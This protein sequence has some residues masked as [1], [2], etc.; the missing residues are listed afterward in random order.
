[1]PQDTGPP[2]AAAQ[3]AGELVVTFNEAG[4]LG[5][6]FEK[7]ADGSTTQIK[8]LFEGGQALLNFANVLQVGLVLTRVQGAP[9]SHSGVARQIK[10][11][12]RPLALAFRLALPAR[13]PPPHDSLSCAPAVR[14]QAMAALQAMGFKAEECGVALDAADGSVELACELFAAAGEHEAAAGAAAGAAADTAAAD[15]PT[16]DLLRLTAGQQPA[17]LVALVRQ[18]GRRGGVVRAPPVLLPAAAYTGS[19]ALAK[20][21]AP[22]I[23]LS[24]GA[25]L[26]YWEATAVDP[27]LRRVISWAYRATT[28]PTLLDKAAEEGAAR[29]AAAAKA[30]AHPHQSSTPLVRGHKICHARG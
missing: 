27:Q 17:E 15:T 7:T 3:A 8:Q 29:E 1:M 26:H 19:F 21:L 5:I 6:K 22:F 4:K 20:L 18:L 16:A 14:A 28:R 2:A 13:I 30:A 24:D 9:V 11:A 23:M 10:D 12:G 25:R